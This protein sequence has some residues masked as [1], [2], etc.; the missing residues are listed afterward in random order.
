MWRNESTYSQKLYDT[1]PV[2]N[3]GEKGIEYL[4]IFQRLLL[5]GPRMQKGIG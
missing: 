4:L 1:D 2:D 3:L 5:Q